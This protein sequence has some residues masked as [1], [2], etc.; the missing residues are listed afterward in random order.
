MN[1]Q[2]FTVV[3]VMVA[4]GVMTITAMALF[5]MQAQATRANVRARD[6][7]VASQIAQNVIERLKLDG[8]AWN[9]I[10]ITD[11][12]EDFRKTEILK[13]VTSATAGNFMKLPEWTDPPRIGSSAKL[14]NGFDQYGIDVPISGS[15]AED[16]ARIRYCASMRLAWVYDT[17]RA[18]RA[19]VRVWWTKEAP[20]RSITA[21][22]PS[23]EDDNVSLSPGGALFES[24]HAV[25]L[26]TVIRPHAL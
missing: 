7:T 24:Y 26:S 13:N 18:M 15:P 20:S 16:L 6:I 1:R 9:T 11:P 17:R 19:D 10:H 8:L 4:L 23:C 21:D 22:F 14:S 5:G 12:D 25:Y 3:E 2:G